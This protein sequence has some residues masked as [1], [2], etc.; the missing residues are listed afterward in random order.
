MNLQIFLNKNM[1]Q[2]LCSIPSQRFLLCLPEV[3][4]SCIWCDSLSFLSFYMYHIYVYIYIH[5]YSIVD[6]LYVG[7]L[8]FLNV[9]NASYSALNVYL[10][11]SIWVY[12]G[13]SYIKFTILKC[14]FQWHKHI[15][16]CAPITTSISRNF[17]SS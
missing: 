17:S 12:C 3:S 9:M 5:I 14:T 10:L 4:T 6:I 16:C 2:N 7:V 8:V 15:H 11:C 1:S 13:K